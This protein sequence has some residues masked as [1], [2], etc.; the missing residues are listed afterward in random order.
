MVA[1]STPRASTASRPVSK[2]ITVQPFDLDSETASDGP[3]SEAIAP[4]LPQYEIEDLTLSSAPSQPPT[5]FETKMSDRGLSSYDPGSQLRFS[6]AMKPDES[7]EEQPS[8]VA[9]SV[10]DFVTRP[11]FVL[12][13]VPPDVKVF[14]S[15]SRVKARRAL[16]Q[17]YVELEVQDAHGVLHKRPIL[18]AS[19]TKRAKTLYYAIATEDTDFL[20][21]KYLAK[22]RSNVMGTQFSL[23]D[24][25]C[26]PS[27]VMLPENADKKLRE[28]MAAMIYE[29]NM[30]GV[31]GPRK[32]MVHIPTLNQKHERKAVVPVVEDDGLVQRVKVKQTDNI[33]TMT[34]KKPQ[35]DNQLKA[36]MLDFHGRVT[37]ASVKNFILVH[38]SN[39]DYEIL[40]FGRTGPDTFS[41]DLQ[42]PMSLVQ[43]F[44]ICLS[45]MEG[46]LGVE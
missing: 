45:S 17:Y 25:G 27:K 31:K 44:G 38:D 36:Y 33:L 35:W 23:Y 26:A 29:A 11:N 39:P 22:L 40:Q 5:S 6:A 10:E 41:M 2:T 30:L 9:T 24:D 16:S 20:R 46:K 15:V 37:Q 34:N 42:H 19:K 18:Y 3:M 21:D 43:A 1:A 13:P 28:E 32:M 7:I 12:E 8:L 14:C 4:K